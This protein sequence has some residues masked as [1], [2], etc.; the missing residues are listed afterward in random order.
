MG[1]TKGIVLGCALSHLSYAVYA[2]SSVQSA[3]ATL[4]CQE[5]VTELPDIVHFPGLYTPQKS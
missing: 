4:A 1:L 2:T 5:L 3:Q